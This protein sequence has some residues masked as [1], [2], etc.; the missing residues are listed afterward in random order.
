MGRKEGDEGSRELESEAL[1]FRP[2]EM[3]AS[4]RGAPALQFEGTNSLSLNYPRLQSCFCSVCL[5]LEWFWSVSLS[6]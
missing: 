5:N 6:L 4:F 1:N 3:W 2:W